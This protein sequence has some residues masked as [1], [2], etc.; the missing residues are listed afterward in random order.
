MDN[1]LSGQSFN[2]E[3]TEKELEIRKRSAESHYKNFLIA[4]GYDVESDPNMKSTPARV[5]KM[6]MNELFL[7]TYQPRP[8]ITTFPNQNNYDGIIFEGGIKLISGCSHHIMPI[9]GEVYIGYIAGSTVIG[10]SKLNRICRW[11]SSRPSLQEELTIKI[12]QELSEIL[13]GNKGVAVYIRASHLCVQARGVRDYSTAMITS[14][15]SGV[16]LDKNDTAKEEFLQMINTF[17]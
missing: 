7:G 9:I 1:I 8:K 6:Y 10:L 14:K 4:L 2:G 12:H 17:K 5:T 3:M 13:E 11:I 15:L 16:F